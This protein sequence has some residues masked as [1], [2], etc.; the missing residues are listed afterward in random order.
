MQLAKKGVIMR[1]QRQMRTCAAFARNSLRVATVAVVALCACAGSARAEK[2]TG[3]QAFVITAHAVDGTGQVVASGPF[4]G[5]GEYRLLGHQDN[6]DGTATDT[7]EFDLADGKVFFTDTYTLG[8]RPAAESCTWLI[9]IEGTYTVTGGTEA[10]TGI[11]GSGTF[12]ATGVLVAGR[13]EQRQCL[14][15]DSPPLAFS[16][17]VRGSGTTTLP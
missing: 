2:G 10:F 6:P 9:E 16:E 14:G 17:V 4:S 13:D 7:D 5:V 12:T 3:N 15:L 11:T 8:V 1:M